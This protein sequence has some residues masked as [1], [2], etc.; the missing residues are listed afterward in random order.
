MVPACG[1]VGRICPVSLFLSVPAMPNQTVKLS[2]KGSYREVA[3]DRLPIIVRDAVTDLFNH[4]PVADILVDQA[5]MLYRL[6]ITT[7]ANTV[8][9]DVLAVA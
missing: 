7:P 4:N 5:G 9:M 2:T 6:Q 8:C 1:L 3:L